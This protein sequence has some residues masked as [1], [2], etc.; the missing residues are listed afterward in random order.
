[1]SDNYDVFISHAWID[2]SAER[3]RDRPSRGQVPL[4]V[5]G[6]KAAGLKVFYD[7]DNI[8][9]FAALKPAVATALANSKLLVAWFSDTYIH[10]RACATEITM[11]ISVDR[12]R[13]LAINPEAA[14]DHVPSVLRLDRVEFAPTDGDWNRLVNAIRSKVES[15]SVTFGEK[16]DPT[17][18][19]WYPERPM[20]STRFTGQIDKLFKLH[21]LLTDDEWAGQIDARGAAVVDGMG[22]AGK[23]L[24]LLEYAYR[25]ASAWTGG[26]IWLRAEGYD[27][28]VEE[29]SPRSTPEQAFAQLSR[30][31]RSLD[32][33]DPGATIDDVRQ[34]I[35][36]RLEA[37]ASSYLWIVDDLAHG[38]DPTLWI[39]PAFNATTVVTTRS[40]GYRGTLQALPIDHLEPDDA[41][42]L[43][44][45]GFS[46]STEEQADSS[47][48]DLQRTG[49]P[50]AGRRRH[51]W[52]HRVGTR[53]RLNIGGYPCQGA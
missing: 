29:G 15:T 47:K 49:V 5:Q 52:P 46:P 33:D 12:S 23:T 2:Q 25:F 1:M 51:A 22:G 39:S 42:R 13:V 26:T 32:I 44:T 40:T 30:V 16:A 38:A 36:H 7:A 53:L 3:V 41:Y 24:L 21:G 37:T 10:R 4:L 20:F 19:P 9:P 14:L 11:A 8:E 17:A 6:L 28:I 48:I 18:T 35:K 34:A 31:A 43:L 45:S 27:R 50:C